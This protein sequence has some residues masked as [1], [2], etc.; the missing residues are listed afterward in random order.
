MKIVLL[1]AGLKDLTTSKLDYLKSSLPVVS[2]STAAPYDLDAEIIIGYPGPILA[3][4]LNDFPL[5]KVIHLLSVGYDT[6]DLEALKKR[7]IR[8]LTAHD[9]S[10]AAI[11]ELVI[12]QILNVNYELFKYKEQQNK[13]EW[14][15]HYNALGLSDSKVLI[16]G[17]GA[18]GSSLALRLNAFEVN[19]TGFRK[20]A[21]IPP[22]FAAIYTDLAKVKAN[23]SAFDYVINTLPLSSETTNL[24]DYS[25]FSKMKENALFINV[26]RGAVVNENDLEIALDRGM[27]RGAIVDVVR[28][29]PL[30]P[31]SLL[32]EKP[33]VFITPHIAYYNNQ[34]IDNI[35]ALLISNVKSFIANEAILGEI[36]L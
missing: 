16:L 30:P 19:V 32:W 29:E 24:I 31:S 11:S 22:H 26:A 6:L 36:K 28:S 15:P 7:S 21:A 4:N 27:I 5:L 35:I 2:F 1:T 14:R 10:S 8:L 34:T 23:L 18:I 12:G 17:T 25:W 33:N 3:L 20:S 13:K 9:T